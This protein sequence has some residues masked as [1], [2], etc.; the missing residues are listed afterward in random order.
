MDSKRTLRIMTYNVHSCF[1]RD[2]KVSTYRVADVIARYDPDVAA[3]QELDSGRPRTNR[4]HQ[5]REIAEH[6]KMDFHFHPAMEIEDEKYGNAIL[7]RYPI[8]LVQAGP[9][10]TCKRRRALESRGA[11]WAEVHFGGK[12]IQII[13]THFGLNRRERLLQAEALLGDEWAARAQCRPPLIICGDM[14]SMPISPVYRRFR[15]LLSDVQVSSAGMRALRTYPS[16]YP[17]ARIDHIFTGPGFEVVNTTVPRTRLTS[18]ASDH[19]PLIAEL[20]LI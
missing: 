17:I 18:A 2:G 15:E 5:A 7:S 3:L 20:A 16:L 14:N 10:P 8:R 4:S 1:G 6:L 12:E 13:N 11:L 9:L 19:L